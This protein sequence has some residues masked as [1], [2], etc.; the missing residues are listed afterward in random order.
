[1]TLASESAWENDVLVVRGEHIPCSSTPI[2]TGL[3]YVE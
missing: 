2:R 3:F 1:M